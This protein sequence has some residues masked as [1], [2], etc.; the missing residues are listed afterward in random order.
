M[1]LGRGVFRLI[2]AISP[3]LSS[4]V[5]PAKHL[6]SPL[7]L[8]AK[9]SFRLFD[10]AFFGNARY[11]AYS[12]C[13]LTATFPLQ[14]GGKGGA[15]TP[16]VHVRYDWCA[17]MEPPRGS[18]RDGEGAPNHPNT[19]PIAGLASSRPCARHASGS[20]LLCPPGS[21]RPAVGPYRK[22]PPGAVSK[23]DFSFWNSPLARVLP[24]VAWRRHPPSRRGA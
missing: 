16:S 9:S 14:E 17:N 2:L 21:A 23:C 10:G 20:Y 6:T 4:L 8:H 24:P 3:I 12:P 7:P 15:S 22:G 13:R 5:P 1:P 19:Q 18:T 11:R